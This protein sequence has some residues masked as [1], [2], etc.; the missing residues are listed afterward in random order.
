MRRLLTGLA[1]LA[2]AAGAATAAPPTGEQQARFY[3]IC[4]KQS[5]GNAGLCTCKR[6]AA[7]KLVDS[8]FM[9]VIVSSMAG[10][11]LAADH[12][13]AYN[14]YIAASTRACGMGG[15]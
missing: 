7:T 14:D 10:K 12:Y 3:D 8:A 15:I 9:E 13:L 5:G 4:L 6:D 11:P 2:L 1:L